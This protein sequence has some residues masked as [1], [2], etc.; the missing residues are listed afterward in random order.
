MRRDVEESLINL[1]NW[2]AGFCL[3]Q[4]YKIT[5]KQLRRGIEITFGLDNRTF[6]KYK[7]YLVRREYLKLIKYQLYEVDKDYVSVCSPK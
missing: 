2:I 4:G 6:K 3:N 1:R 7:N 5:E